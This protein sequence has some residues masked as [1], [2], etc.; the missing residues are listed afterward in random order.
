MA[1]NDDFIKHRDEVL[2]HLK[3][4]LDSLLASGYDLALVGFEINAEHKEKGDLNVELAFNWNERRAD[5]ETS[6]S[7]V[8][9]AH[10]QVFNPPFIL[11]RGLTT[12]DA[13]PGK[14]KFFGQLVAPEGM[15]LEVHGTYQ[16]VI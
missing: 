12:S 3:A 1:T 14:T 2:R 7:T 5:Q 11:L 16:D 9:T 15:T 4:Q 13:E 8:A 10:Q 6:P